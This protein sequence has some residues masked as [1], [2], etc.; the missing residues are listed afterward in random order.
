MS[1]PI[2]VYSVEALEE[3]HVAFLRYQDYALRTLETAAL[4]IRRVVDWLAER[5]HFW[6][7]EVRRRE[8][9][10]R[11]TTAAFN[12]CKART[13]YD[14]KSGRTTQPDCTQEWRALEQAKRFKAEAEHELHVVNDMLA[15]VQR[16]HERYQ[17]KAQKLTALLHNDLPQ[18]V[19]LLKR[20]VAILR[21]TL[22]GSSLGGS[23]AEMTATAAIARIGLAATGVVSAVSHA[24]SSAQIPGPQGDW[25]ERGIQLASL[26]QIDLSDSY[27]QG[28]TDYKKVAY[29][30]MVEGVRKLADVVL[31]AVCNGADADYFAQL[32]QQNGA[33]YADGYH[34]V[35]DAFYGSDPI[36]LEKIGDAYNV[37][38][39]YHRL[40]IAKELGL[41][42]IP[43]SI[44]EKA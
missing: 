12:A 28:P 27:V 33:A 20:K 7:N 31:P 37:I 13:A 41:P 40:L 26:D 25:I 11:Q 5:Q 6:R 35:Y 42:E 22:G 8:E 19:A 14:A 21:S 44:V 15:Q 39:G 18:S 29:E 4:E 9:F 38:G 24:L 30:I 3:L 10:V 34:R 32:D 16:A 23:A 36:R 2:T 1:Q 43:A 17:R